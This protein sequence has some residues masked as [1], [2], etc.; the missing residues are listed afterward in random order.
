MLFR[1]DGKVSWDSTPPNPRDY[2]QPATTMAAAAPTPCPK[3]NDSS[4]VF[5]EKVVTDA[6]FAAAV[7]FWKDTTASAEKFDDAAVYLSFILSPRVRDRFAAFRAAALQPGGAPRLAA[8]FRSGLNDLDLGF[9]STAGDS[10]N[11][12]LS[13]S[14]SAAGFQMI[15]FQTQY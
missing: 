9:S 12:F 5:V 6:E 13:V 14:K 7:K 15:N 11:F 4:Y 10:A 3:Q 1:S 8:V 2:V